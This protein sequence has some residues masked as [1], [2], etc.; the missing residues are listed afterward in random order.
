MYT[1]GL[2][3]YLDAADVHRG[4]QAALHSLGYCRPLT[5]RAV[6][7]FNQVYAHQHSAWHQGDMLHFHANL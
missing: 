4:L 1:T 2:Q 3:R 5:N 6:G 7:V